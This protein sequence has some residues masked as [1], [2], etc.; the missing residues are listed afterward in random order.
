[1]DPD[2]VAKLIKNL[3]SGNSVA[4]LE[5]MVGAS[6]SEG[7][8][9]KFQEFMN[10]AGADAKRGEGRE[11]EIDLNALKG[12]ERKE[13]DR[14]KD[15]VTAGSFETKSYLG[16][17]FR[18]FLSKNPSEHEA[19]KQ[20]PNRS[21]QAAYRLEWAKKKFDNF[22]EQ[23]TFKRSWTR[24]DRTKGSYFN[25]AKLVQHLGGWTS[26]EAI[27][28]ATVACQKCLAMGFPW[29]RIHPQTELAE[30][31]ILEQSWEESFAKSWEHFRQEN[32]N[33]TLAN[34]TAGKAIDN[35]GTA[36]KSTGRAGTSSTGTGGAPPGGG[37]GGGESKAGSGKGDT[38][39]KAA[40]VKAAVPKIADMDASTL[41]R[42][43]SK[44]KQVLQAASCAAVELVDKIECDA[45]WAW[46][47]G[48]Q[49]GKLQA[50]QS[51]LK[52]SLSEW[53]KRFVMTTNVSVLKKE[54]TTAYTET[55]L[56]KF[57][58]LK[59]AVE[60]LQAMIESITMAHGEICKA[61]RVS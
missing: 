52:A 30:F 9:S 58:H 51:T 6:L 21:E 10:K 56:A 20:L 38:T 29:L 61:D 22:I 27:K 24:V 19:F 34:T 12:F 8:V 43:G 25:F 15:A 46:A 50:T 7:N 59:P 13:Y 33:G 1:M 35:T 31:L 17:V 53:H 54:H 32:I 14:L 37:C 42:E 18:E 44:L 16:N 45:A 47:K 36:G 4:S 23:R 26:S 5:S 28:G 55:E 48:V 11:A 3:D 39:P 60:K 57:L 49:L 2:V 40:K 41:W